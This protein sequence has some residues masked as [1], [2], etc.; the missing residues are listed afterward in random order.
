MLNLCPPL[1]LL[2]FS[3]S[4]AH[5]CPTALTVPYLTII[6]KQLWFQQEHLLF[7]ITQQ[8]RHKKTLP[9]IPWE[10]IYQLCFQHL[11]FAEIHVASNTFSP[12]MW[13]LSNRIKAFKHCRFWLL[14][15]CLYLGE[16]TNLNSYPQT[17]LFQTLWTLVLTTFHHTERQHCIEA[18]LILTI[19]T[20]V[21]RQ[22][23]AHS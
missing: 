20:L 19:A 14:V 15:H 12:L 6:C 22:K 11:L 16:N 4:A 13:L 9:F 1:Y 7:K 21:K 3:G 5:H 8:L 2:L 23:N 17:I 10:Y 18:R